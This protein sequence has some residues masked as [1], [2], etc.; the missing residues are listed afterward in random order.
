MLKFKVDEKRMTGL[1]D[2]DVATACR[3][4]D[5]AVSITF[6]S[7]AC[8]IIWTSCIVLICWSSP[9]CRGGGPPNQPF[10]AT[11][12]KTATPDERGGMVRD[13]M[14]VSPDTGAWQM[15]HVTLTPKSPLYGKNR[16]E[17]IDLLGFP[18]GQTKDEGFVHYDIG[19]LARGFE[20]V[21]SFSLMFNFSDKGDEAMPTRV[22]VSN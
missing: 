9:G 10:D 19:Y 17:I 20:G 6:D 11:K 3:N 16:K 14:G 18:S 15:V 2:S 4:E 7:I 5:R 13:L 21:G 8:W 12:W 1:P 22:W